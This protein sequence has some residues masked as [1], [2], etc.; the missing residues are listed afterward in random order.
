MISTGR[1]AFPSAPAQDCCEPQ[2]MHTCIMQIKEYSLWKACLLK[3]E[4]AAKVPVMH[5]QHYHRWNSSYNWACANCRTNSKTRHDALILLYNCNKDSYNYYHVRIH[6]ANKHCTYYSNS[7][8]IFTLLFFTC[9]LYRYNIRAPNPLRIW[10]K[11]TSN[12]NKFI[13][14]GKEALWLDLSPVNLHDK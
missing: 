3:C 8:A 13:V 12:C 7:N 5:P 6:V 10:M 2:K 11:V 1:R 4:L 9:M 14:S